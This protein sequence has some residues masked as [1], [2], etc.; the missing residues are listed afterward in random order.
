MLSWQEGHSRLLAVINPAADDAAG[1]TFLRS[2]GLKN[3]SISLFVILF[4]A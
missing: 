2:L 3:R 1:T 4:M